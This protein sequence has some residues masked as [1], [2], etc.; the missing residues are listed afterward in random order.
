MTNTRR[1][2]LL[3][4]IPEILDIACTPHGSAWTE[5]Q[6]CG[7]REDDLSDPVIQSALRG[8]GLSRLLEEEHN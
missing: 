3:D 6:R 2:L 1:N 8:A 4:T 7:W 5:A